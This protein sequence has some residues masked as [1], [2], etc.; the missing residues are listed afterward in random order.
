[1]ESNL[2]TKRK[3]IVVIVE[4]VEKVEILFF[5]E[6]TG[7]SVSTVTVGRKSGNVKI[8]DVSK[9]IFQHNF[10]HTVENQVETCLK[11]FY[12]HFFNPCFPHTVEN[13]VDKK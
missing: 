1:M 7:I 12:F 3:N 2:Y 13:T 9:K 10:Q 4:G 11:S 6:S 5:S 8:P